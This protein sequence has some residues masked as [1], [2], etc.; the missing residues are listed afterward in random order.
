M[1]NI[2]QDVSEL[3]F[4]VQANEDRFEQILKN[5]ENMTSKLDLM[6]DEVLR[7]QGEALMESATLKTEHAALRDRVTKLEKE[8]DKI[9]AVV[10]KTQVSVAKLAAIG[11]GSGAIIAGIIKLAEFAMK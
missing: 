10:Q 1:S 4:R 11:G 7:R 3:R 6:K 2:E 8:Q 5:Q 9:E